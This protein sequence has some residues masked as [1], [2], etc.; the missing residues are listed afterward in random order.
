MFLYPAIDL[1]AGKCVRLYQGD[2]A[3][4]TEYANDPIAMARTFQQEGATH[5][6]V[7]D[8]DGTQ[9]GALAQLPLIEKITQQTSLKLQ[10]GGGIRTTAHIQQLL[11]SGVER[12]VIG[13]IAVTQ[14]ELLLDWLTQF[15]A[16]AITLALDVRYTS[17][18]QNE[19]IE[20]IAVPAQEI[21][22]VMTHGW[23]Q[24][25]TLSLWELLARYTHHGFTHI[26]CTDLSQ[27]GTLQG[28]NF[29]L[30][31]EL[32]KKFPTVKLQASGG[33]SALTDLQNLQQLGAT[34]AIIGKALYE[35]RFT[36]TQALKEISNGR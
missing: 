1:K 30:Y 36:L 15:S 12:V 9:Q 13:S 32:L 8:L 18:L 5:L 31:T 2:F 34:A 26:L 14:P 10:V 23:Q 3:S 27:D 7:V 20:K 4:V 22:I 29:S 19:S 16:D 25:S 28:P 33:V 35:K 17:T 24:Q 21:P 6:H 11:G